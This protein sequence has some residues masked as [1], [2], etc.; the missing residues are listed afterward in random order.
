ME[1]ETPLRRLG[2]WSRQE[3][4]VTGTRW[5]QRRQRA[6][7]GWRLQNLLMDRVWWSEGPGSRAII[8]SPG[9]SGWDGEHGACLEDR[10]F[11]PC[12]GSLVPHLPFGLRCYCLVPTPLELLWVV[13]HLPAPQLVR[14]LGHS[15]PLMHQSPQVAPSSRQWLIFQDHLMLSPPQGAFSVP[16]CVGLPPLRSTISL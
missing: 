12:S 14:L 6:L 10:K 8:P 11:L 16:G 9:S 5:W 4:M 13:P 3:R 2:P 7:G 1:A 15:S